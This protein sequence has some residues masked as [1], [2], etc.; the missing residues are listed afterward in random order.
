MEG[1]QTK[2]SLAIHFF[3]NILQ[4]NLKIR[5]AKENY[6]DAASLSDAIDPASANIEFTPLYFK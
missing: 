4:F 1:G 3:V 6:F 2:E 5:F